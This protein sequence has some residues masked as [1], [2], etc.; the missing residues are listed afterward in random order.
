M[1]GV[2]GEKMVDIEAE[3][4]DKVDDVDGASY[5][6][7]N[8]R[9]GDKSKQNSFENYE[10]DITANGIVTWALQVVVCQKDLFFH[11]SSQNCLGMS[12]CFALFLFILKLSIQN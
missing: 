12:K 4:R 6:I 1:R 9:A 11:Q 5:E 2:V 7:E 3:G 8:V 10:G